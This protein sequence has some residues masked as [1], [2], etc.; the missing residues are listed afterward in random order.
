MFGGVQRTGATCAPVPQ[1]QNLQAAELYS[2]VCALD[3][4]RTSRYRH[5]DLV[6]QSV[7]STEGSR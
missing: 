6:A 2:A 3:E 5:L 1:L 7:V 4:V